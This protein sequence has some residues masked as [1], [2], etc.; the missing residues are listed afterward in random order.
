MK[1]KTN[2]YSWQEEA[3]KKLLSIKVGALYMEMGTG[4]TRTA[5]ELV[6]RRFLAKKINQALWLCPC[7]VMSTLQEDI[8]K[9]SQEAPIKIC[10]IETLSSSIKKFNELSDF[11]K[12]SAIMLIV[13]ESNLVKNYSAIRTRRISYLAKFC[14][15]RLILT[16]TPVSQCEADLYAQWNILDWRILG[17]HSFWGFAA[18]HLEYDPKTKRIRRVLNLDYLTD[19]IKPYSYII[20]KEDVLR[21][22]PKQKYTESFELVPEQK[23]HYKKEM[24]LFLNTLIT[25]G[26]TAAIYRTFTALQ[27]IT[28][29]R[30]IISDVMKPIKHEPFFQN[31]EENPRIKKLLSLVDS[32]KKTIIWCKFQHEIEDLYQ[33]LS[34]EKYNVQTLYGKMSLKSRDKAINAFKNDSQILLANKTC[35][36]YGLNLQFCSRAIYYNNDWSWATRAQSEDRIH[37]LGQE[38][39]V[40]I[41]DIYA[42]STIDARIL[43]CLDKKENLVETFRGYIKDHN[44]EMWLNGVD[45]EGLNDAKSIHN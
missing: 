24:E 18:N 16:G 39:I 30:R 12:N 31:P 10:G 43:N 45:V 42:T 41:I 3:V 15:Y 14:P 44:H 25:L 1:L 37:R 22:L 26:D 6:F 7:S 35:A 2:L 23:A 36:G 20:K 27:E 40:E 13:D 8:I 29:G 21:L 34:K 38:S 33:V 9:H 32:N 28:S 4:K 11:C 5:L 17:Y 19:K